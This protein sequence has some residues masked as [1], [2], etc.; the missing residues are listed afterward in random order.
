MELI[1]R[2][3]INKNIIF[4]DVNVHN[5]YQK[6]K[7]YTFDDLEKQINIVKNVLQKE[8]L[9][10]EGETALIGIV[11]CV[12]QIATFFACAELGLNV[13]IADHNRNDNWI[14][15]D[16]VDPKTQSLLPINYFIVT[17]DEHLIPKYKLF[18]KIC[19]KTVVIKDLESK[20]ASPNNY[21]GCTENS[22][23]LKCTSSGTTG[24]AKLVNHNH[25][26]LKRLISRNKTFYYGSVCMAHNLNHGS[27]PATYFLPALCSED[28]KI[29]VSY[30]ITYVTETSRTDELTKFA[31]DKFNKYNFDHLMI[32]YSYMIDNFLKSGTYQT[33]NLYTL[34]TI[35]QQ[36]VPYFLDNKI[37]NIISI[38]GSNETSGP[39]FI[40]EVADHAFEENKYRKID[41]FY[42]IN[43]LDGNMLEVTMPVYGTKIVTNDL[44]DRRN[45][46][47]YHKGRSDLYRVNGFEVN[48]N[49]YTLLVKESLDAD[50]IIDTAKDSLY[51]A[52][53]QDQ[54]VEN[55]IDKICEQI[56][57]SSYNVHTINKFAILD[58][59]KFMTGIKLDMELLRDYFRKFV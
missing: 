46:D 41:D 5:L 26:F 4:K 9:C 19:E 12:L 6:D 2:N 54:D 58:K 34:S 53:W 16:Y 48:V 52:V 37:K 3:I 23:L 20:D 51:I 38:F 7:V 47:Y 32:P 25:G 14:N 28:T 13:V 44:F 39:T 59:T 43:L 1:T 40:N 50:L 30:M 57:V 8:Y 21:L 42:D 31:I 27:S 17:S 15:P 10:K 33:L 36:W 35:K 45:N 11:P 49:H 55:H 18:Y 22:M 29:F 56:K 24:T